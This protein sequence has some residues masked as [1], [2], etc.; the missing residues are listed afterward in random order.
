MVAVVSTPGRGPRWVSHWT[1]RLGR[2]ESAIV[3]RE[4]DRAAAADEDLTTSIIAGAVAALGVPAVSLRS[5]EVRLKGEGAFGA[6]RFTSVDATLIQDH[7]AAGTVVLLAG[8]NVQRPDGETL[9]LGQRGADV[10]AA[11][12][13][14]VL[15]ARACHV[16]IE[17]DRFNSPALR[18]QPIHPEALRLAAERGVSVTAYS[19]RTPFEAESGAKV[20]GRPE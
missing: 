18:S 19:F 13:A 11:V 12:L 6:G 4:L 2:S 1:E 8:G 15:G 14:D 5:Q 20:R 16:I 9:I 7:L 17:L 10:V 3:A